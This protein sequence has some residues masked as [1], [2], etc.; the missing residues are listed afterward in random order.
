MS[1]TTRIQ[2]SFT[3]PYSSSVNTKSRNSYKEL[4]TCDPLFYMCWFIFCNTI[5]FK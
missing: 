2:P 5:S 3:K 4:V 1:L